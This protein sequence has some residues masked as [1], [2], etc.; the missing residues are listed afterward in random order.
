MN[1]KF[2]VDTCIFMKFF[3]TSWLISVHTI[4]FFLLY[5]YNFSSKPEDKILIESTKE[6]N[7]NNKEPPKDV[8]EN[9]H[10]VT[11]VSAELNA[12]NATI[13]PDDVVENTNK[14]LHATLLEKYEELNILSKTLDNIENNIFN[15]KEKLSPG[16]L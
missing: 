1:L 13:I 3:V 14:E 11:D 2:V 15:I 6:L 16:S 9:K 12:T 4:A 7:T 10:N 8:P 5:K